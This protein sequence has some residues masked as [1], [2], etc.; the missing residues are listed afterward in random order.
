MAVM[1]IICRLL[2][3]RCRAKEFEEFVA[4]EVETFQ[5]SD[6]TECLKDDDWAANGR[7][8]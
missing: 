6:A 4:G 2:L 5:S 3:K 1:Y 7:E 8:G